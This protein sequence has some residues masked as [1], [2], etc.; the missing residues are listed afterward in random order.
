MGYSSVVSRWFKKMIKSN[1][2]QLQYRHGI[3]E[4]VSHTMAKIRN[5]G[6][7]NFFIQNITIYSK[8]P[9]Q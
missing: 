5:K 7:N 9:I 4:T 8:T 3:K 1:Y 6:K 2:T